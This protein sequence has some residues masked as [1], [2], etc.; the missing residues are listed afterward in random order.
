VLYFH[1]I[2]VP[3]FEQIY[4]RADSRLIADIH[5]FNHMNPKYT[6]FGSSGHDTA[7]QQLLAAQQQ[8]KLKQVCQQLEKK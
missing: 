6:E 5:T 1:F 2:D 3:T 4:I 8:M 7:T